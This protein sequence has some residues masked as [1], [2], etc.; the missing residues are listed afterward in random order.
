MSSFTPATGLIGGSLIGLSAATLLLG[1]GDILGA[2]GIVSSLILN[3]WKALSDPSQRWKITFLASFLTT[4]Q[5]YVNF[6]D[7]DMHNYSTIGY[8]AESSIVSPLGHT[9]AGFLV[10]FG[11]RVRDDLISKFRIE[12]TF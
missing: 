4:V 1:N 10:G 5:L 7:S 6:V 11:T 3:P 8:G 9:V 12:V 2:S